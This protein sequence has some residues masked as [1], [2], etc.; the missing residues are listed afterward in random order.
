MSGFSSG[1]PPEQISSDDPLDRRADVYAFGGLLYYMLSATPP[2]EGS[3]TELLRR[4]L[5]EKPKSLRERGARVSDRLERVLSYCLRKRADDR[6]D[7]MGQLRAALRACPE[8]DPAMPEAG[9]TDIDI[10]FEVTTPSPPSRGRRWALGLGVVAIASVAT[11]WAWE[12]PNPPLGPTV[13]AEPE[14]EEAPAEPPVPEPT[15]ET[16]DETPRAGRSESAPGPAPVEPAPKPPPVEPAPE[17][18]RRPPSRRAI[19]T[20]RDWSHVPPEQTVRD[21]WAVE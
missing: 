9:V 11:A 19:P 13:N 14:P 12:R 4:H 3:G 18:T 16:R 2:F 15:A 1:D 20:T 7:D 10:A 6:F 8:A 17:E 5:R 21:P